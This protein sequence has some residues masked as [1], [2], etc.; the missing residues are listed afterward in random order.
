M[1][2]RT[3]IVGSGTKAA[4]A[5]IREQYVRA[6]ASLCRGTELPSVRMAAPLLEPATFS[7]V[8][9][10]LAGAL[11]PPGIS[12]ARSKKRALE[13]LVHDRSF[14][15]IPAPDQAAVLEALADSAF[16]LTSLQSVHE[17]VASPA[18]GRLNGPL[19]E[20]LLQLFRQL[21]D[22]LRPWLARLCS[23]RARG[24]FALEDRDREGTSLVQHLLR[25][26][27]PPEEPDDGT[28]SW[29]GAAA[30]PEKLAFEAGP[31]GWLG[32]L[33][34]AWTQDHPAEWTRLLAAQAPT[35]PLPD[36]RVVEAP[37][38]FPNLRHW[39]LQLPAAL[40]PDLAPWTPEL[41]AVPAWPMADLVTALFAARFVPQMEPA[42]DAPDDGR[43]RFAVLATEKGDRLFGWLGLRD[44]R[45]CVRA[46]HG[47]SAKPA[48]ASRAAPAREVV[49]PEKGVDA[50]A[51]E[52]FAQALR[53]ALLPA[54]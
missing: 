26:V 6:R 9:D 46:P 28:R 45:V 21:P 11:D 3:D 35:V 23:R 41:S 17:L 15:T 18:V 7:M 25:I 37:H 24:R 8:Q 42:V 49:D 32:V 2:V 30:H 31:R 40:T 10:V 33:E 16:D 54:D 39:M 34:F 43:T 22:D 5:E 4:A 47:K 19:R 12:G 48:G 53:F 38:R 13:R 27:T 36:G 14:E 44:A 1:R 20:R 52:T 50:V 51:P 29:L